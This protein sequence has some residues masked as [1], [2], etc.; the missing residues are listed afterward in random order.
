MFGK[1]GA[2]F[3]LVA[4]SG[5]VAEYYPMSKEATSSAAA[6]THSSEYAHASAYTHASYPKNVTAATPVW[7]YYNATVPTTVVVPQYTTVCPEK[8]VLT[9]NGVHY[10]ATK[11]E[12]VTVT[13]CPCTITT[14]VHV[15]TSSLCPPG[16]TPTAVAPAITTYPGAPP[17]TTP[18]TAPAVSYTMETSAETQTA[19]A[20][21]ITAVQPSNSAVYPTTPTGVQVAG[22]SSTGSGLIFAAVAAFVGAF[23]L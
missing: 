16:V 18:V 2:L 5:V 7:Q 14:A 20:T 9:Y 1:T 11:G 19:P 21:P 17:V 10:S 3:G 4:V 13:N 23:A 6:Y 22:A 15:M 8:T 12:T